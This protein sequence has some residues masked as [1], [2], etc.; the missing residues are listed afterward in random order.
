[1]SNT[2]WVELHTAIARSLCGRSPARLQSSKTSHHLW[3]SS[4]I[5]KLQVI[6]YTL[7][8]FVGCVWAIS[9]L[10]ATDRPD[11]YDRMNQQLSV[12]NKRKAIN[13]KSISKHSVTIAV[14]A[15]S[16]KITSLHQQE[17]S[18]D[19]YCIM[20]TLR[21]LL[22]CL[23]PFRKY[24]FRNEKC[25]SPNHHPLFSCGLEEAQTLLTLVNLLTMIWKLI[26]APH[27]TFSIVMLLLH[28]IQHS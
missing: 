4:W 13:E 1:M 12:A 18:Q 26:T 8:L 5:F 16:F 11:S 28:T 14:L 27:K 25:L 6:T 3:S 10:L 9:I 21:Q 7:F 24:S 20:K 17:T 2:Q 22:L 23:C 15:F 19:C